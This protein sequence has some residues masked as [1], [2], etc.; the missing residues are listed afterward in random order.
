MIFLSRQS[1]EPAPGAYG[2]GSL[3]LHGPHAGAGRSIHLDGAPG[4]LVAFRAE[5]THEVTPVTHGE[6]YTVV[7]WY[8]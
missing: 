4:A 5:T 3:L 1:A 8:R 7:S 6:R 2:G